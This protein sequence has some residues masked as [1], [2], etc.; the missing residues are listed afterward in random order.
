MT[1][2][3]DQMVEAN[4]S[5]ELDIEIDKMQTVMKTAPLAFI[6]AAPMMK[7]D[8]IVIPKAKH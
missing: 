7:F 6:E 1:I 3:M 5:K 2:S 4:N 8:V